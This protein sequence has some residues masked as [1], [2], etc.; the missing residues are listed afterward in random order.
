MMCY[1]QVK[2]KMVVK[3]INSVS[4]NAM[5]LK[6]IRMQQL[7]DTL[8]A[9]QIGNRNRIDYRARERARTREEDIIIKYGFV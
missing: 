8:N 1:D 9:I 3:S 2:Q 5:R 6:C 4:C 7:R